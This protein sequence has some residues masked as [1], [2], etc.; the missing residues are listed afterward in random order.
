MVPGSLLLPAEGEGRNAVYA[1]GLGFEVVAFDIS[2]IAREKAL[3][4][5]EERNVALTYYVA[6]LH[7][8][9]LP[10]DS[11]DAVALIYAHF[12]PEQRHELHREL[13][14][15]LRPGGQI[16]LEA[17]S[18]AHLAFNTVNPKAGGPKDIELLYS[19]ADLRD[20]FKALEVGFSTTVEVELSEGLYHSG[21]SSVVRMI[22]SKR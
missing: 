17:F 20:D 7:E 4:L 1:A 10:S 19:E 15:I 12:P 6:N 11:F 3:R 2:E 5:A 18:K 13:V 22:A 16:I 21:R 14:R 9:D 8:L